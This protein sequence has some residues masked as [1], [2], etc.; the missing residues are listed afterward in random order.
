MCILQVTVHG[1]LPNTRNLRLNRL[2]Q[3]HRLNRF[4]H[5]ELNQTNI[6]L[7]T[8]ALEQI[9]GNLRPNIII[10][11]K[12]IYIINVNE[13]VTYNILS[14]VLRITRYSNLNARI[15]RV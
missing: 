2:N 9:F 12:T 15:S 6:V 5:V 7:N 1:S 10:S 3:K 8:L 11:G 13:L 14:D 4:R